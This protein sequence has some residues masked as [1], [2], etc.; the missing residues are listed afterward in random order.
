M[1][2]PNSELSCLADPETSPFNHISAHILGGK[3]CYTS[4]RPCR[5]LQ[6]PL[7]TCANAPLWAAI[8]EKLKTIT[9]TPT[10]QSDVG[11]FQFDLIAE[12]KDFPSI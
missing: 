3:F 10:A 12:F 1:L 11:T 7:Q 6:Y 5:T 2:R 4:K 9:F 8:N